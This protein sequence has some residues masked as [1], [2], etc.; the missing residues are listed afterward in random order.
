[1]VTLKSWLIVDLT[2]TKLEKLVDN[3]FVMFLN[4]YTNNNFP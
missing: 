1:M 2:E 4:I 3:K